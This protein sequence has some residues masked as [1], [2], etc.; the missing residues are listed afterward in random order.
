MGM[1]HS[2][3]AGLQNWKEPYFAGAQPTGTESKLRMEDMFLKVAIPQ[4]YG[5]LW[6]VQL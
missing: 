1:A 2:M 5:K 3:T 6:W 4:R